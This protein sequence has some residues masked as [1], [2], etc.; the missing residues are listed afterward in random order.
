MARSLRIVAKVNSIWGRNSA[1]LFLAMS[2]L[3]NTALILEMPRDPLV[4]AYALISSIAIPILTLS[5]LKESF[6]EFF[7]ALLYCGGGRID[8]VSVILYTS[9]LASLPSYPAS[10][11]LSAP[12]ISLTA[13]ILSS[14]YTSRISRYAR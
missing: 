2:T 7:R 5:G 8:R 12:Y 1:I 14:L 11:V 9:L 4:Y 10:V 3:V 13:F 6:E